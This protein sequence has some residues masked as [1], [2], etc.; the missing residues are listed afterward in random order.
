MIRL[1]T[2]TPSRV[3][4][5]P[6]EMYRQISENIRKDRAALASVSTIEGAGHYVSPTYYSTTAKAR[7]NESLCTGSSADAQGAC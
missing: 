2:Q 5:R 4:A 1:L 7:L 6:P 3:R